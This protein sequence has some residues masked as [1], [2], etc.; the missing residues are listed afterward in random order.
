M[1]ITDQEPK[2]LGFKVNPTNIPMVLAKISHWIETKSQHY[3]CVTGAHPIMECYYNPDLLPIFNNSGISTPDG[4][5]V[6]WILQAKGYKQVQRVYG[7][8]LLMATCQDGLGKGYRH[9][10][11]GS[12]PDVAEKMSRKLLQLLPGLQIAGITCPPFRPLTLEEIENETQAI[13]SIKADIIWVGLGSP[14]QDMWM[15]NHLHKLEAPVMVGVGAAFDFIAGTKAHAPRWIQRNGLEWLFRLASEPRRL[16]P[17]Y[18]Q[19]PLFVFLVIK[20]LICSK[21]MAGK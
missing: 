17:R 20:E 1:L 19:Y 9:Y 5:S 21:K 11:Y 4:M 12:T 8:D 18:R 10:F 7:P 15:S 2:I 13:N 6:V 16:W 3:V 14:K